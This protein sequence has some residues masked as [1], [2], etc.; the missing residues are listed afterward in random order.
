MPNRDT[1]V[2]FLDSYLN[3]RTI[4]DSSW[5]G[6]Q[7]E[8]NSS[9]ERIGVTVD[10]GEE[11]F[12]KA[13]DEGVDF[14]IVHHGL[15][16][17]SADPRLCDWMKRRID[18]LLDAGISLYAAHLPL[19]V[20]PEVGNNVQLVRLTGAE[21]KEAFADYHGVK[22]GWIGSRSTP[23]PLSEIVHQLEESLGTT[24]KVLSFGPERIATVGAVSGGAGMGSL[25][26]ALHAGV[27]LYISGEAVESY[28]LAR[29]AGM[30]IVYCGHHASETV[31]VKALGEVVG[32]QFG[33]PTVFVD[34]PTGL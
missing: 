12:R 11:T 6:L 18:I 25:T 22:I 7:V 3:I 24:C 34:V 19:D 26:H 20:H 32:K 9:V 1:L 33:V 16:W 30:N 28:H 10:S 13:A 14:L 5:N 29:D 8:G 15:F 4:S 23:A 2:E 21:P 27:D 17:R 31:G